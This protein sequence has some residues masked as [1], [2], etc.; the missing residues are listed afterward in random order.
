[1]IVRNHERGLVPAAANAILAPESY[2]TALVNGIITIFNG[3]APIRIGASGIVID[4]TR[5]DPPPFVGYAGGG[6]SNLVFRGNEWVSSTSSIGGTLGNCAGGP[7]TWGSWLTC[8]ETILDFSSINGKKHGYVFETSFNPEES[9]ATPIIGMGR[10]SHEA[11][12]I[13]PATGYV[14][15]TEDNRNLSALFRYKPSNIAGGLGSLQQGG[16]L[17]AARITSIVR[18]AR[19]S[20]LAQTNDTGLLNPDIGDEYAL[21]WVD[22]ADPDASPVVVTGQ[23]GGVSFGLMSGPTY[24]G[25]VRRLRPHEPR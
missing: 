4:P 21:E 11:V 13:D 15:E 22:I 17:Q 9:I 16:T 20:T 10:F 3:T 24:S 2:S 6:T 18:Q 25:A 1:M 19:P 8:E 5:P 14:Y 7:M 12:A 23:P